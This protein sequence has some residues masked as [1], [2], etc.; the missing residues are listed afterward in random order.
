LL[1]LYARPQRLKIVFQQFHDEPRVVKAAP[2]IAVHA[3]D[4]YL[5]VIVDLRYR[6]IA[7]GT[8][9]IAHLS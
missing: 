4:Q 8:D 9:L 1:S 6:T 3:A 7:V 5:A 2:T